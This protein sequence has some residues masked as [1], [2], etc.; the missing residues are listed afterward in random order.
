MK[1]TPNITASDDALRVMASI[2]AFL[3]LQLFL[4]VCVIFL[5]VYLSAQGP[6]TVVPPHHQ[7]TT[8]QNN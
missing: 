8:S 4:I 6:K 3:A 5:S 7:I 1:N 2:I